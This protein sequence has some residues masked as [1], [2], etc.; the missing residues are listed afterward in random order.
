M[1]PAPG[2]RNQPMKPIH[3]LPPCVALAVAAAW[4]SPQRGANAR[5]EERNRELQWRISRQA[6]PA[7]GVD[8]VSAEKAAD[9]RDPA[10]LLRRAPH[11]PDAMMQLREQVLDMGTADLLAMLDLLAEAELQEPARG[12]IETMLIDQLCVKDPEV[13]LD[14][15]AHRMRDD[16]NLTYTLSHALGRWAEKDPAGAAAWLDRRIAEGIFDSK[17]LDGTSDGRNRLEGVLISKL[18]G[19]PQAA[20]RLEAMPQEHRARVMRQ[21]SFMT[22]AG[23]DDLEQEAARR[24]E[25][26]ELARTLLPPAQRLEAIG[27]LGVDIISRG[28]FGSVTAYL[29]QIAANEDERAR[30]VERAVVYQF[31]ESREKPTRNDIDGMRAWAAGQAPGAMDAATGAAL[32]RAAFGQTSMKLDEAA[33]MALEYHE[34][35]GSDD[36]LASFIQ[37]AHASGRAPKERLLEMAGKIRDGARR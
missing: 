18:L 22:F 13:V 23:P 8:P 16:T 1:S 14:R 17:R 3:L 10:G 25:Y 12:V 33:A 35:G 7:D 30:V 37:T 27:D 5:M 19:T 31:E 21:I 11:Q 6:A 28:D 26:A 9:R 36:L 15:F 4:I 34:A 29:Q 20:A 2:G 32:G 24:G